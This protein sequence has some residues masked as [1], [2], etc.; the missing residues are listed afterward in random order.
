MG[1]ALFQN[2][3]KEILAATCYLTLMLRRIQNRGLIGIFV[4]LLLRHEH[5]GRPVI[6]YLVQRL[7]SQTELRLATLHLFNAMIELN[8]EDIMLNLVLHHLLTCGH[9]MRSQRGVLQETDLNCLS[10]A[11]YLSLV[12]KAC[13]NR[14]QQVKVK[15]E[16]EPNESSFRIRSWSRVTEDPNE[17]RYGQLTF[18]PSSRRS[19]DSMQLSE[20]QPSP[21]NV[22]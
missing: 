17:T 3:M 1:S 19:N 13:C 15:E 16:N 7:S 9:V 20:I 6:D 10:A 8:C 4:R 11:K 18:S 22:S 14:G 2:T 12:P 5:E 21:A